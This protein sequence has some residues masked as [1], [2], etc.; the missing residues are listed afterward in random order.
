MMKKKRVLAVL[1]AVSMMAAAAVGC[2]SDGKKDGTEESGKQETAGSKTVTMMGWY[3]EADMKGV[4]EAINAKMDQKYTLEYT[5]VSNSD[6]NNVLSTQLAA[7]EGPDIVMDGTGFVAKVK[8]GNVKDITD[9]E[10]LNDFNEAGL[11]LTSANGKIYGIPSYGW[12]GGVWYNKDIL[13]E[14]GVEVPGTFDEYV[15]A[16]EKIK[17]AGHVPM[18]FGLADDSTVVNSLMGHLENSFYHNNEANGDGTGFDEKFAKGEVTMDGNINEPVKQWAT[19]IDKGFITPEMLGISVQEALNHFKTGEVAFFNGGPWQYNEIKEAGLNFGM[20]PQL[21]ETG[22]NLYLVGGPAA[23][24][25]I[26]VNSKNMDGA[27]AALEAL[28]S[29]EVQ[30]AF[31]DANTGGFSYRA[32]VT[33]KMPEEYD[34]VAEIINSGNVECPWDRWAINM[35]SQAVLDELAAQLQGVISGDITTDECVKAIDTKADSIRYE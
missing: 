32:G 30:Q 33:V 23:C 29:V 28:A 19:L 27:E 11:T 26:N 14:C 16:C 13:A 22:E 8:A 5:Y 17:A 3:D 15:A 21:N 25:G 4:L 7:G 1:L 9:Y 34:D 12:F 35:P 20:I 18:E 10:L 31:V 24:F 6:Y 2:G